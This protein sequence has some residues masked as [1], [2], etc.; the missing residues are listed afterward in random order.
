MLAI[1]ALVL[2]V[3][4]GAGSAYAWK[5]ARDLKDQIAAAPTQTLPLGTAPATS[6]TPSE[7]ASPIATTTPTAT[8]PPVVY[9]ADLN[10]AAVSVARPT[11]CAVKYVDVD[12]ANVGTEAGHE[13]Y[14]ALKQCNPPDA[15]DLVIYVDRTSGRSASA[16]NP[17][18]EACASLV[19]GTAAGTPLM[20]DVAAGLTFCLLTNATDAAAQS[21]PQRLAIVQVVSIGPENVQLAVSTYHRG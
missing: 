7:Q 19:A 16:P 10:R 3:A 20:L 21:L 8:A 4:A 14:L 11:G 15:N 18:T 5:T 17:T 12:T 6:G 9:V 2:A 1:V 13:F